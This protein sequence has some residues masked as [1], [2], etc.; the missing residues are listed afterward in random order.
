MKLRKLF[1]SI[2]AS[3]AIILTAN[4]CSKGTTEDPTESTT[5]V[6]QDKQNIK[7]TISGFYDCMNTL[8][9][10]DFSNFILYSFFQ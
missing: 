10:G 5:T 7:K 3:L 1:F 4:S 9:D 6:A 8:D 2:I